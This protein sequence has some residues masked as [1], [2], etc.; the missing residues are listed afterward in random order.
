[1]HHSSFI[2]NYAAKLKEV[3]CFTM[4][5]YIHIFC[6]LP[7]YHTVACMWH[8]YIYI[9]LVLSLITT[10]NTTRFSPWPDILLASRDAQDICRVPERKKLCMACA[11]MICGVAA[12]WR[13]AG[14]R[15]HLAC[16]RRSHPPD[17]LSHPPVTLVTPLTSSRTHPLLLQVWREFDTLEFAT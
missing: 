14:R 13:A 11:N 5:L 10:L 1:M 16:G 4:C 2:N 3:V 12:W 9:Y 17:H 8:I 6:K 15:S 7:I